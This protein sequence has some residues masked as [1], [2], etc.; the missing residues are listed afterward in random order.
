MQRVGSNGYLKGWQWT[1]EDLA[2]LLDL[3]NENDSECRD[4]RA[5]YSQNL[6]WRGRTC[7]VG[8]ISSQTAQI[9]APITS[10]TEPERREATVRANATLQSLS[11]GPTDKY[12]RLIG[13]SSLILFG[14]F[15]ALKDWGPMY[16]TADW[17]VWADRQLWAEWNMSSVGTHHR[18]NS[19]K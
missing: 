13:G 8:F 14:H 10:R 19:P 18:V 16:Y 6:G 3:R 9:H 7:V 15:R 17:P 12:E 2:K 1:T 5:I 11:V 4:P